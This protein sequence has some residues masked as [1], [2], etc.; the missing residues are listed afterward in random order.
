MTRFLI[1]ATTSHEP[2]PELSAEGDHKHTNKQLSAIESEKNK[3][4]ERL[5]TSTRSTGTKQQ[6][7]RHRTGKQQKQQRRKRRTLDLHVCTY[8]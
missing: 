2:N 7:Q 5:H 8:L 6:K 1:R 3:Q 4:S